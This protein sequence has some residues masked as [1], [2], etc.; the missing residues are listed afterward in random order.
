MN[1]FQARGCSHCT[2]G[3]RGRIALFEVMPISR[4]IAQTIMAGCHAIDLL[5]QAKSE[6]MLTLFQAG[7]EQIKQGVTNIEEIQRSIID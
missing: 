6:G 5:E 4:N 2:H 1:T 7:L 3:F